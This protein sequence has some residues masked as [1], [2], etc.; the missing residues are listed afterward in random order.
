[1]KGLP[2]QML[3]HLIRNIALC[4]HDTKRQG[5][6]ITFDSLIDW[7]SDTSP[8]GC[9]DLQSLVKC[10]IISIV[11][12]FVCHLQVDFL[13]AKAM[14]PEELEAQ[15]KRIAELAKAT[16]VVKFELDGA[17]AQYELFFVHSYPT[18]GGMMYDLTITYEEQETRHRII[19]GREYYEDFGLEP[20]HVVAMAFTFLLQKKE[21]RHTEGTVTQLSLTPAQARHHIGC[22]GSGLGS[23]TCVHVM[24]PQE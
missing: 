17:T 15:Q 4:L 20:E 22:H 24:H 10:L 6:S 11:I 14:T 7:I 2:V 23:A 18:N 21:P 13:P 1:M 5:G 19:L 3:V 8:Q 12:I 9:T 16:K